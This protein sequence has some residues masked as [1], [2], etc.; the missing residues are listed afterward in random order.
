[1][2]VTVNRDLVAGRYDLGCERGPA[3]DLFADEKER[4]ARTRAFEFAEDGRC[5]LRMGPVVEGDGD[6]RRGLEPAWNVKG[7]GDEGRDRSRRRPAPGRERPGSGEV[8]A[9]PRRRARTRPQTGAG[10]T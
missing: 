2:P 10:R 7:R 8:S 9:H 5:S 1:M 6:A 3:L 4:R